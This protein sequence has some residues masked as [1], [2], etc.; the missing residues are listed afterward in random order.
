MGSP[1][2]HIPLKPSKPPGV[3]DD[4]QKR[5]QGLACDVSDS[6]DSASGVMLPRHLA[7]TFGI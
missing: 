5:S 3:S 2:P 1:C 7:A 6:S 4:G